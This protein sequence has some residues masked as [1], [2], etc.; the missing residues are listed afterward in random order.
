MLRK[1]FLKIALIIP[2]M[3]GLLCVVMASTPDLSVK[4][5]KTKNKTVL[6]AE[7]EGKVVVDKTMHDFGTIKKD[8]G[9]V[10]AVFTVKNNIDIPIL[11]SGVRASCGC[12]APDWTKEPIERGKTGTVTATYTPT[13]VG[14]F[15]K[16][17]TI[18]VSEGDKTETFVVRIK[19][20]VE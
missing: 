20:M 15:E 9:S 6:L 19:G 14:P 8:A 7:E 10:S 17:V 5:K 18:N 11:I 13:G 12:T 3:A 16:S 4:T 2:A 1:N